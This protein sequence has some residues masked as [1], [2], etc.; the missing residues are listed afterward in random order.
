[1]RPKNA[2]EREVL[3]LSERLPE[4]TPTQV[5]WIKTAIVAK[6][7]YT[8]GK[9]CWCS[10]CGKGW[11]ETIEGER[12]RCPHCGNEG[13]VVR[14]RM[15]TGSGT[16]YAQFITTFNGYQVIRYILVEWYFRKGVEQHVYFRHVLEKWC[17][18]GRP[19][20]TLGVPI[21][22]Y[23]WSCREPY[24][25]WGKL[26]VKDGERDYYRQWMPVTVYPRKAMLPVYRKNLGAAP[27]FSEFNAEMII[28]KVFSC[29]YFERLWKDGSRDKLKYL[30]RYTPEFNKYWHSVKVALRHGYEPTDWVSY[31]DHLKAM[32]FLHYDMRSPRYVAPPDFTDLHDRIMTQYKNRRDFMQKRREEK[33]ALKRALEEEER[34]RRQEEYAKK[35]KRSFTRRIKKFA[36]LLIED[37]DLV[38]RPLMSIKEFMEEGRAMHHCVFTGAYYNKPDS[39]VLSARK[40]EDDSRVETIEVKL[41]KFI[42]W[43]SRGF[44]N[45]TTAYHDKIQGLVMGAMGQIQ[46]MARP[47]RKAVPASRS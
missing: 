26:Q 20:V 9:S 8:P 17:Q 43:Q 6:N 34:I 36:D 15:S 18:P 30:L 13:E 22:S 42:I 23:P 12:G 35:A 4:L 25:I 44:G 33:E 32:R 45:C 46:E 3:A 14:G 16:A 28:G 38:I 7:I 39:L 40:K 2:R 37:K 1:M 21:V 24:S 5:Q 29:P 10:K 47:K 19:T 27:D 11:K 31:F 41:D